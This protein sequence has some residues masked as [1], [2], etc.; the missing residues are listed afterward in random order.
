[1]TYTHDVVE[2]LIFHG[3]IEHQLVHIPPHYG[4]V[5]KADR[6]LSMKR[7]SFDWDQCDWKE[8]ALVLA[9]RQIDN[10]KFHGSK[11][12]PLQSLEFPRNDETEVP[13]NIEKACYELAFT[14]IHDIDPDIE[15]MN[16]RAMSLSFSGIRNT[17]ETSYG[18]AHVLA[19]IP[20]ATAWGYLHP[21]L[22]K[23]GNLTLSRVS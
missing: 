7:D 6:Y 3:R 19:G 23:P 16:S 22:V 15:V 1:M 21:Y 8:K 13:E 11:T 5:T 17:Y 10:L 18:Q 2:S 14:L 4:T 12:D 20:S 9:T